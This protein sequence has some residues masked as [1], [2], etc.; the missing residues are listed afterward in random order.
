MNDE[1]AK[2]KAIYDN[3]KKELALVEENLEIQS[4]GIYK[5]HFDFKTSEEYKAKLE[6]NYEKQK[7]LIKDDGAVKCTKAWSV[8][9]SRKEG[10]PNR[11]M[12]PR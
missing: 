4:F 6:Q 9:G 8:E 2:Y 10:S 11:V 12:I 3:L 7:A 1:Y 5:P